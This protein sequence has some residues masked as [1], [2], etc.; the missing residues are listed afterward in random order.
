MDTNY[1]GGVQE[2]GNRLADLAGVAGKFAIGHDSCDLAH[3]L[4][5]EKQVTRNLRSSQ[6]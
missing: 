5:D 3:A 4:S 1:A 2:P 6:L